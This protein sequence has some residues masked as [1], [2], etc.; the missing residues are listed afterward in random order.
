[1]DWEEEGEKGKGGRGYSFTYDI[2]EG[3]HSVIIARISPPR[4]KIPLGGL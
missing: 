2:L 4:S 3:F 1:M